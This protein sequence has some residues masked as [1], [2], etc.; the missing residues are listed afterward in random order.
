MRMTFVIAAMLCCSGCASMFGGTSQEV[1]VNTEPQGA[2]CTVSRDGKVIG[3]VNPTPGTISVQKSKHD[4]SISCIKPEYVAATS[5]CVS[6]VEGWVIA[7]MLFGGLIGLGID[8]ATGGVNKYESPIQINLTPFTG[9]TTIE[10]AP[11]QP[12]PEPA[13][14]TPSSPTS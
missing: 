1:E 8:H 11:T 13:S 7:N 14:Q 2:D 3:H 6:G 4:L 5:T 12:S 9:E 10:P